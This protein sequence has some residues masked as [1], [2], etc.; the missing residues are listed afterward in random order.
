[1][2]QFLDRSETWLFNTFRRLL[3]VAALVA[4]LVAVLSLVRGLSNVL[5]S[6]DVDSTDE[7]EQVEFSDHEPQEIE[8]SEAVGSTAGSTRK[9][10][11]TTE[12]KLD[13][14]IVEIDDNYESVGSG[15]NGEGVAEIAEKFGERKDEF[16]DGFVDWS[17]DVS[18]FYSGKNGDGKRTEEI[19]E[20]LGVYLSEFRKG[21]EAKGF[22]AHES[23]EEAAENNVEGFSQ[24]LFVLYALG[25]VVSVI[26]ILLAFK[27]EVDLRAIRDLKD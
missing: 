7:I 21:V 12:P 6:P 26:V 11:G 17:E 27:I 14:R 18:D 1:M 2:I 19:G 16:L 10:A 25:A 23:S 3:V 4:L 24:L 20:T 15:V 9:P 22:E 8:V 5:D 13:S